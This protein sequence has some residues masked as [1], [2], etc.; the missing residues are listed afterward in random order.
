MGKNVTRAT[1]AQY[2]GPVQ[3][4]WKAVE[5]LEINYADCKQ[6]YSEMP[7]SQ[8]RMSWVSRKLFPWESRCTLETPAEF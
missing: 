5:Q 8:K 6:R 1:E 4:A 7:D 3:P 2:N